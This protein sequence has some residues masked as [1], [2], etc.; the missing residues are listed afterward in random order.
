MRTTDLLFSAAYLLIFI[1][2]G[3]QISHLDSS[4]SATVSAQLYPW[5]VIGTGVFVGV[6]ETARTLLASHGGGEP[7]FSELWNR[8]LAPRRLL[9]LGLFVIYLAAITSVGF[10][11]ATAVFTFVT[12]IALSPRRDLK[13]FVVALISTAALVGF[14]YV[15]LVVYLQAFLP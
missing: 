13:T 10:L 3:S 6:I 15:L 2:L 9:L 1:V 4:S 8:A 12:M 5:L 7:G 14:I 11:S